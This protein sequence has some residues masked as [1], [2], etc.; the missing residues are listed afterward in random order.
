[1]DTTCS[2]ENCNRAAVART[3]CRAHWKH[4]R[5]YGDPLV[6]G[7]RP[8]KPVEA[9][10]H[11]KV[12][13]GAPDECWEWQAYCK[14]APESYGV[15]RYAV[16]ESM[17]VAHRVAYEF[18]FGPIPV[19]MLVRHSCDNPP[20]CNPSHLLLGTNLDNSRDKVERGRSTKGRTVHWGEGSG[21]SAK[22][23]E[24]QVR[25][26]RTRYARGDVSQAALGIEY[27]ISQT[28]IGTIVRRE[29]WAPLPDQAPIPCP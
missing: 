15:F 12:K 24:S 20:C 13:Q 14:P 11:A 10:F 3:W 16:G 4:W 21:R 17:R 23:T 1:M 26:I 7:V 27:G 18:A 25:E 28:H 6:N 19:G 29:A 9:R 5:R 22:L 8:R 2:I